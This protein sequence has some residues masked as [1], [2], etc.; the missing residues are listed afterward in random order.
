L[1]TLPVLPLGLVVEIKYRWWL[2]IALVVLLGVMV[3]GL[4]YQWL[5]GQGIS[6]RVYLRDL[7]FSDIQSDTSIGIESEINKKLDVG[8]KRDASPQFYKDFLLSATVKP[9]LTH[10]GDDHSLALKIVDI[11]GT[12]D[13]SICGLETLGETVFDTRRGLGCCSDYS[14]SF[15]FYANFLGLQARE[16]SLFNHTTVEYFN[17]TTGHWQWL[18]PFNRVEIVNAAGQFLSLWQVRQTP[19]FELLIYRKLLT[20]AANFDVAKYAGYMQSQM[21]SILWR[22]GTNF[23]EVEAWDSKMQSWGLTKSQRQLLMLIAGVQPHWLMV[24]THANFFYYRTLRSMLWGAAWLCL[25]LNLALF[26]A[27]YR[28]L[29]SRHRSG[30]P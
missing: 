10:K 8:F 9:L 11:L 21:G 15:L 26:F 25:V 5:I 30:H 3:D 28:L 6:Q 4:V 29:A 12:P 22:R 17:R 20:A 7:F 24:T 1:D 14:K 2:C 23:L 13:G 16:V 19:V 18:D 27:F